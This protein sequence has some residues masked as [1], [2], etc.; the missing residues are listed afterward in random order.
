MA[1]T[2]AAAEPAGRAA[3]CSWAFRDRSAGRERSSPVL[4]RTA[5]RKRNYHSSPGS[6]RR[7]KYGAS[8]RRS[9]TWARRDWGDSADR[10]RRL[11][12]PGSCRRSPHIR[13]CRCR[14]GRHSWGRSQRQTSP[15]SVGDQSCC[16]QS[17][18]RASS[19][20]LAAKRSYPRAVIA[21]RSRVVAAGHGGLG[22]VVQAVG[23]W[24]PAG[25]SRRRERTVS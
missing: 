20:C 13:R 15:L 10:C 24:R 23:P 4:G 12:Q 25:S 17:R 8:R 19:R 9:C 2:V 14:T 11:G 21:R 7:R 18:R 5:H 6:H 1:G 22:A 16:H 3:D